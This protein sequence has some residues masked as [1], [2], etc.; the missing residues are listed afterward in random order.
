M[1]LTC[2]SRRMQAK[3]LRKAKEVRQQLLDIMV[4]QKVP[5]VSCG[6][7]WDTV[8]KVGVVV[9]VDGWW[10]WWWWW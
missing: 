1:S 4:Q 9:C 5:V 3:G 10:W 8:R 7:D 6:T 2:C